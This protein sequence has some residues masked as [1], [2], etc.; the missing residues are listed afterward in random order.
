MKTHNDLFDRGEFGD[1]FD[2]PPHNTEELIWLP[3]ICLSSIPL[4]ALGFY[5]A[6]FLTN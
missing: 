2:S 1:G 4:T 6:R 5:L 3:F